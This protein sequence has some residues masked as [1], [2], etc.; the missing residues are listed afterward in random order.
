MGS[1]SYL[2]L[3]YRAW[4]GRLLP[5]S[6]K[7]P[8]CGT[9][10]GCAEGRVGP[11]TYI[12]LPS[13]KET[14][15]NS[16][17]KETLS[18]RFRSKCRFNLLTRQ[19]NE[20]DPLYGFERIL[21]LHMRAFPQ[22]NFLCSNHK[23]LEQQIVRR[24]SRFGPYFANKNRPQGR[25]SFTFLCLGCPYRGGFRTVTDLYHKVSGQLED[26]LSSAKED[27][28]LLKKLTPSLSRN[29]EGLFTKI[30]FEK[31]SRGR[32]ACSHISNCPRS[33]QAGNF[34]GL[35]SCKTPICLIRFGSFWF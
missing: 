1:C 19:E 23:I 22:P 28:D 4:E 16:R 33:S 21:R 24:D 8:P 7:T 30:G 32:V 10:Y 5:K 12:V 17:V 11:R 3:K 27:D 13:L 18:K 15:F 14:S 9:D 26:F 20:Q 29:W 2:L 6:E 25:S 34:S 35:W 31:S